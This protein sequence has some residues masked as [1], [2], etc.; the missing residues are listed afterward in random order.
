VE[1]SAAGS[2]ERGSIIRR[3]KIAVW[4]ADGDLE[5]VARPTLPPEPG[6]VRVRILSA[7]VCGSDLHAYRGKFAAAGESPGHEIGGVVDA[8]GDGAGLIEG[9]PV[10]VDPVITCGTCAYCRTANPWHCSGRQALGDGIAEYIRVPARNVHP[11][12]PNLPAADAAIVE[13]LAVG[14]RGA[15]QCRVTA[16]SRV[17]IIG[18]GTIGLLA[19]V[20]ARAAGASQVFIA[21]RHETQARMAKA[22]GADDVFANSM[23][24]KKAAA[25]GGGLTSIIETVGGA[26]DTVREAVLASS[27]GTTICLLGVFMKDPEIPGVATVLTEVEIV[28]SICYGW[29][30]GV[31]EFARAVELAGQHYD[32]I[33]PLITHRFPL[34]ETTA[35]FATAHDKSTG[36]IKVQINP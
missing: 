5:V 27:P 33:A 30:D 18:A 28:G 7:G 31:S 9:T 1:R 22:L 17:L 10:A 23:D 20:A 26:A 15:N 32:G 16:G 34:S 35:A 12:P 19:I 4:T 3:V 11:L 8:V 25:A 24:A 6:W 2:N 29:R 13:P 14:V 36:S 21:A